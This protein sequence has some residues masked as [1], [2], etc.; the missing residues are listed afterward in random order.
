MTVLLGP[1]VQDGDG[2]QGAHRSN[3]YLPHPSS[4]TNNALILL[5]RT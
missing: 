5:R 1:F 4:L 2:L 3:Y